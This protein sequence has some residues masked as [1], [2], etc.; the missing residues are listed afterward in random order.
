MLI[1][2]GACIPFLHHIFWKIVRAPVPGSFGFMSIMNAAVAIIQQS[3][4]LQGEALCF[5]NLVIY[6]N[7]SLLQPQ[8]CKC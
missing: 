2:S 6:M 3:P 7:G 8:K 4:Q 1:R 5:Y